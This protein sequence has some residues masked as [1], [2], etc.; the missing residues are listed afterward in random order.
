MNFHWGEKRPEIFLDEGPPPTP[1]KAGVK[2]TTT[3]CDSVRLLRKGFIREELNNYLER[4]NFYPERVSTFTLVSASCITVAARGLPGDF[5]HSHRQ[6]RFINVAAWSCSQGPAWGSHSPALAGV[7]QG[8]S[9]LYS[10]GRVS[11]ARGTK[12][13][14]K[15]V[16]QCF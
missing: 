15:L 12:K 14:K 9:E 16:L 8:T 7:Y 2:P 3:Q 1:Q 6:N 11:Q 13:K 5:S 4:M 10:S